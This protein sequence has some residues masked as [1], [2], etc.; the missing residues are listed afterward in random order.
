MQRTVSEVRKLDIMHYFYVMRVSNHKYLSV[1]GIILLL[2]IVLQLFSGVA[3]CF[4]LVADAMLIPI[5]R[6]EEDMEDL[7]TDDFFWLHERGVDYIF[8]LIYLHL[9]RKMMI[10]N[11]YV[12]QESA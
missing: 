5:V 9:M 3:I 8:I 1:L 2:V 10:L 12:E 7:Y 4:S 11:Y 6:N